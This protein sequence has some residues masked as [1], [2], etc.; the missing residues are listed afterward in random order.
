MFDNIRIILVHTS[1]PGNIGAAARA[2][3]TMGLSRLY[4]VA[5]EQ[6]PHQ[7]ATTRAAGAD[8]ILANAQIVS[9]LPA[10][11][12]GCDLVFATSARLRTL[13]W[14]LCH[15]HAAAAQMVRDSHRNIAIVFGRES[16]GLTNEELS[17]C[18]QHIYIPTQ[19]SFSS[20]NLAAAVQVIVYEIYS[21]TVTQKI[22]RSQEATM[23]ATADQMASFYTHLEQTLIQLEFLDAKQPK[24]LMQRLKRLFNRA[25]VDTT[26]IN[27]LRGILS[28]IH[29]SLR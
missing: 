25:K 7:Q 13:P 24:M 1:H 17:Y 14:P 2:M 12:Q 4:L 6:F 3:K 8:D 5:P 22:P 10:A 23:L 27:I 15:P 18:H 21:I 11:L 9:D 16:A 19:D 26:E 20:L 28:A 29:R